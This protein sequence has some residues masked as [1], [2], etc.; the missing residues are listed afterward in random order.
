MTG[1]VFVRSG[2]SEGGGVVQSRRCREVQAPAELVCNVSLKEF[3][4]SDA[5]RRDGEK[6]DV[7]Q[8]ATQYRDHLKAELAKVE[9]FLL[10]AGDLSRPSE[11][12]GP[13][14]WLSSGIVVPRGFVPGA[15]LIH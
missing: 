14:F 10:M 1:K 8:I 6:P 11:H 3:Q 5:C 4:M 2:L 12:T 15:D 7:L 13:D 9:E